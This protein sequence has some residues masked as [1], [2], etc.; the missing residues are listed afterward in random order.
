MLVM[1]EHVEKRTRDSISARVIYL[2]KPTWWHLLLSRKM[3]ENE[4]QKIKTARKK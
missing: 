2:F 1:L 3:S 4:R